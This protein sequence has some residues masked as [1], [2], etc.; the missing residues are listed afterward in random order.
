MQKILAAA[1]LAG[2]TGMAESMVGIIMPGSSRLDQVTGGL[3]EE[4]KNHFSHLLPWTIENPKYERELATLKEIIYSILISNL[5]FEGLWRS[6]QRRSR[7][8]LPALPTV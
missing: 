1:M 7:L 3:V 6:G 8:C 4:S 5:N 2:E